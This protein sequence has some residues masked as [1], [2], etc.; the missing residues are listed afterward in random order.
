M[1]NLP[2]SD[3]NTAMDTRK[4]KTDSY[5][6]PILITFAVFTVIPLIIE[7]RALADE[8]LQEP[9][10]K[11]PATLAVQANW[12]F[13]VKIAEDRARVYINRKDNCTEIPEF[14]HELQ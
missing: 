2:P 7:T 9:T 1:D 11:K 5:P 14:L 10:Y 3:Y 4:V 6:L 8:P 13:K 12:P